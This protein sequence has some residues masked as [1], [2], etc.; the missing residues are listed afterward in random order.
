VLAQCSACP[1]LGDAKLGRHMIHA[2]GAVDL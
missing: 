1:S 2:S